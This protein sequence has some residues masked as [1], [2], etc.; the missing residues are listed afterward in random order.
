[1][2]NDYVKLRI[3]Y[4][5]RLGFHP[6]NIVKVLAVENIIVSDRGVAK[7]IARYNA[8]GKYYAL[9]STL[10]TSYRHYTTKPAV[11]EDVDY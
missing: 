3:L 2:Y 10:K 5:D 8:T 4:L 1:M 11:V 9:I 6:S 7:Y